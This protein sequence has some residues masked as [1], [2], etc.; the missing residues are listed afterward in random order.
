MRLTAEKKEEI[1]AARGVS[2]AR[3]EFDSSE[4]SND[5]RSVWWIHLPG[6]VPFTMGGAPMTHAEALET[7]LCIWATTKPRSAIKVTA[8]I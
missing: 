3:A 5:K 4:I 8:S 7:V 2:S 1:M 6:R